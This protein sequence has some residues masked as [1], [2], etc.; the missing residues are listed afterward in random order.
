MTIG[1]YLQNL[2]IRSASEIRWKKKSK[3]M[4][5]NKFNHL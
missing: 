2:K 5:M 3:L 4:N 1:R